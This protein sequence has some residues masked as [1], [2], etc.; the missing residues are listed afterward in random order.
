M[1]LYIPNVDERNDEFDISTN[2]I[3]ITKEEERKMEREINYI[4][5]E[6]NKIES[7]PLNSITDIRPKKIKYIN[8]SITKS[9]INFEMYNNNINSV[10]KDM[11]IYGN[12]NNWPDDDSKIFYQEK[13]DFF[14][15]INEENL[16]VNTPPSE[17]I[18]QM[19]ISLDNQ[20]QDVDISKVLHTAC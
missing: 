16:A 5:S 9:N 17:N 12:P 13:T 8:N 4:M 14:D 10:M 2:S 15:Y 3:P 6:C 7:I 20:L 1:D 19:N 18:Q 11:L